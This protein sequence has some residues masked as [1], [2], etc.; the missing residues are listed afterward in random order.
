MFHKKQLILIAN[1]CASVIPFYA[2][3]RR[4]DQ[5]VYLIQI[6]T[7]TSAI[8][9]PKAKIRYQQSFWFV[10]KEEPDRVWIVDIYQPLWNDWSYDPF[11][12]HRFSFLMH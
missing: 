8:A 7:I 11:L 3:H 2:E 6:F 5:Y 10:P 9:Y 1:R 12:I 4:S